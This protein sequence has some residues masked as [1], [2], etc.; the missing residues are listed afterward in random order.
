MT[1]KKGSKV[2]LKTDVL[3]RH[4]RSVPSHMGY[5]SAQF[6]WR[7]TLRKLKGRTGVVT[8]IFPSSSHVNVKFGKTIIGIGKNELVEVKDGRKK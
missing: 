8:M 2:K 3:Q 1:I 7:D 4:S 5:T 6:Q